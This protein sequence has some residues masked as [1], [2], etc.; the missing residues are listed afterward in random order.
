ML[1]AV[2][3]LVLLQIIPTVGPRPVVYADWLHASG[4]AP[5]ILIY[6]HYDVQVETSVVVSCLYLLHS[7][8]SCLISQPHADSRWADASVQ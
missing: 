8:Q 1:V 2:W 4:D 3:C 6:G 5:T 7:C